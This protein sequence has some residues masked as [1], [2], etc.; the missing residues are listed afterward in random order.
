MLNALDLYGDSTSDDRLVK[1]AA[2][3]GYPDDFAV[4]LIVNNGR[5]VLD[6]VSVGESTRASGRRVN[7]DLP[8][9]C[10]RGWF[11][12]GDN[13]RVTGRPIGKVFPIVLAVA[14]LCLASVCLVP[15]LTFGQRW[16][17]VRPVGSGIPAELNPFVVRA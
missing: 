3:F 16:V 13:V 14:N 8:N 7:P 5:G 1:L 6:G 12:G 2:V 11:Y 9:L 17:L 15:E 10:S 4:G